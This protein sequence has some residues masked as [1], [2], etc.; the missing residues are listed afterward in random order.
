MFFLFHFFPSCSGSLPVPRVNFPPMVSCSCFPGHKGKK[1]LIRISWSSRRWSIPSFSGLHNGECFSLMCLA[2]PPAE[3][4]VGTFNPCGWVL[5]FPS[6][7]RMPEMGPLREWRSFQAH[8]FIGYLALCSWACGKAE[9][10]G[11]EEHD[12]SWAAGCME[13]RKQEA[14]EEWFRTIPPLRGGSLVTCF[15]Q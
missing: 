11:E 2:S 14:N 10:C 13:T 9:E 1:T 3:H 8:C 4:S 6:C 15:L 7:D 12:G 5:A